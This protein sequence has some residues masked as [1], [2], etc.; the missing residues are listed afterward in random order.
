MTKKFNPFKPNTPVYTGMFA[1]RA[2]EIDRLDTFLFQTKNNNP[3]HVLILGERGIGKTSLLFVANHF[4]KG[5]LSWDEDKYNFLAVHIPLQP[6]TTLIDLAKRINTQVGRALSKNDQALTFLKSSWNF[7]TRIQ[8][9]VVSI[10]PQRQ[11]QPSQEELLNETI[12]SIVDT[13]KAITEDTTASNLGLREKKDGLVIL[14]DEA[15]Q[16]CQSLD[17]GIFLKTLSEILTQ[18]NANKVLLILA[19]LPKARD[20]LRESHESSLRLFEEFHLTTLTKSEVASVVKGGLDE[21]KE[22]KIIVSISQGAVER[23]YDYS[24]GYPH[25]IQQIAYSAYEYDSDNNID[26]ADVDAAMYQDRGA[27]DL[28]GDRY[29]KDL[30]YGK[31]KKDS[32]RE[33]LSIMAMKWNDWVSLKEIRQQFSGKET[34]LT[35]GIKALRDRNIIL[36]RRGHRGSYRLQWVGFAAWIYRVNQ[37]EQKQQS[38]SQTVS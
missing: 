19:G 17:L 8:T 7:L 30:Y 29:Y 2:T 31:I 10:A 15:D 28:I 13:V 27:L 24:E 32:Y 34:T 25:F 33:I 20:I 11:Y 35:N 26:V 36:S 6:N 37:R 1:G 22:Q 23:I 5:T 38:F 3:S 16:A 21:L 14:I 4:A 12:Y 18:E 9:S